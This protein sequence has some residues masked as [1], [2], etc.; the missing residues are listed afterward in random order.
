MV[1]TVWGVL[2]AG[3]KGQQLASG[4]DVPFLSL[5]SQPVI[6][7]SLRAF[8]SC[9]D[10]EGVVIVTPKE[11]LPEVQAMAQLLGFGKVRK[12]TAGGNQRIAS[13]RAGLA[14]LDDDVGVVVIHDASRPCVTPALISETVK[15]AKKVGAAVAACPIADAVKQVPKGR[16]VSQTLP[17]GSAWAAQTPQAFKL[18]VL[19]KA[20]GAARKRKG[21]PPDE[22]AAVEWMKKDVFVVPSTD[23]NIRI[24]SGDDLM[25]AAALL[26]SH[27]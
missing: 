4:A 17:A 15:A 16:K 22:A 6:S 14:V 11:R 5:G 3:G 19:T 1:R 10:I 13:V 20:L 12:I 9:H 25:M 8:Q 27:A 18:E 2:I 26:Q 21:E 24:Q 7:Y 23:R